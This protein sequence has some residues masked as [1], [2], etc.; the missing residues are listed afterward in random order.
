MLFYLHVAADM[1]VGHANSWLQ[2]PLVCYKG[3]SCGEPG[4][5]PN[6]NS[7]FFCAINM[8]YDAKTQLCYENL[9]SCKISTIVI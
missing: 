9:P 5:P 1:C 7:D 2:H 4:V 6:G 3:V 8:L